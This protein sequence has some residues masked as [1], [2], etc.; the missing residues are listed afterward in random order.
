MQKVLESTEEAEEE[1]EEEVVEEYTTEDLL[2]EV[3][4]SCIADMTLEDKVAGL[5]IIS[6]EQ[7]TGQKT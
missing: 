4:Q 5:F 3:V 2:N 7:L 6:P 1:S